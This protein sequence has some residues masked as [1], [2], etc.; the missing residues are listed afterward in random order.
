MSADLTNED[1]RANIISIEMVLSTL[2]NTVWTLGQKTNDAWVQ[3]LAHW[4]CLAQA[5]GFLFKRLK[6]AKPMWNKCSRRVTWA[7]VDIGQPLCVSSPPVSSSWT[8]LMHV[9]SMKAARVSSFSTASHTSQF[10][11]WSFWCLQEDKKC[12]W[13]YLVCWLRYKKIL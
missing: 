7:W 6:A 10:W 9:N 3:T 4:E 5:V 11:P 1:E 13:K 12:T 8:R 2:G